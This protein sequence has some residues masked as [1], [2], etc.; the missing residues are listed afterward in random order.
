[1]CP[2]CHP[3][4]REARQLIKAL[5]QR[6]NLWNMHILWCTP[7]YKRRI[8][9]WRLNKNN[10]EHEIRAA[11]QVAAQ[12]QKD[13]LSPVSGVQLG[14]RNVEWSEIRRYLRRKGV[15]DPHRWIAEGHR[16]TEI[17]NSKPY[18]T[19]SE[20]VHGQ[21]ASVLARRNDQT[22]FLNNAIMSVK[23][24]IPPFPFFPARRV[25]R[26]NTA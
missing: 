26:P 17:Q 2:I 7:P 12:R 3:N 23:F 22:A 9:L 8:Q 21:F 13:G 10:E 4:I 5:V 1:V 15:N 6:Q 16:T 20:S 11:L 24:D 25:L 19:G 18:L 14:Q